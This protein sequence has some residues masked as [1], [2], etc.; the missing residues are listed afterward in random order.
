M[1][2]QNRVSFRFHQRRVEFHEENK[3]DVLVNNQLLSANFFSQFFSQSEKYKKM[4]STIGLQIV[5]VG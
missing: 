3:L 4:Y 5:L 1:N 2:Q